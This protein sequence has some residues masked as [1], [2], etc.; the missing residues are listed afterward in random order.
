MCSST[1]KAENFHSSYLKSIIVHPWRSL[2]GVPR[3]VVEGAAAV[4][5]DVDG[6]LG[7]LAKGEAHNI[8]FLLKSQGYYAKPGSS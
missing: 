1:I 8:G 7:N 3:Q 2:G 5:Q 4:V 6:H